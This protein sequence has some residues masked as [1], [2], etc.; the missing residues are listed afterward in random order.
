[1]TDETIT[2]TR[3]LTAALCLVVSACESDPGEELDAEPSELRA[4]SQS[5]LIARANAIKTAHAAHPYVDNPA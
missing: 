2:I 1:M 4:L 3:L 5:Q